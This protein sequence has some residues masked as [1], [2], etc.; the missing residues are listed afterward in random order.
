[1]HYVLPREEP[2]MTIIV[3]APEAGFA[4]AIEKVQPVLDSLMIDAGG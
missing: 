4:D 2:D 1:V 3:G